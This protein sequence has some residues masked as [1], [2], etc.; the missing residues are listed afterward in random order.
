MFVANSW[1][2]LPDNKRECRAFVY[3][4]PEDVLR[5]IKDERI[6]TIALH[7]TD[8][9]GRWQEVRVPSHVLELQ[10][11]DRGIGV[12]S[13][14]I[15][16]VRQIERDGMLMIPDPATALLDPISEQPTLIM[17]CNIYD[18]IVG[19]RYSGD[20]RSIAQK[21]EAYLLHTDIGETVDFGL[22]LEYFACDEAH[23]EHS[24]RSLDAAKT[25]RG[26]ARCRSNR[27]A[28][29]LPKKTHFSAP[30]PG[31]LE[32][33]S[34]QLVAT[35]EKVGITVEIHNDEVATSGHCKVD[36]APNT[37]TR[38]ADNLMIY[39]YV[40]ENVVRQRGITAN[41][42]PILG[43]R[44]SGVGVYQSIWLG[45]RPLFAGN[46]Y[47]GSAALMR[48]YIAGLVEH[49]AALLPIC[50]RSGK[51]HRPLTPSLRVP[52]NLDYSRFDHSSMPQA[53]MNSRDLKAS[54]AEFRCPGLPGNPYLAFAAML[55]AGIDGFQN[56]LYHLPPDEPLEKLYKPFHELASG[57]FESLLD[58]LETDHAFLLQ[59]DVFTPD[60]I[61]AYLSSR[62]AM[63]SPLDQFPVE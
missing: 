40:V 20:P 25:Q 58:A 29:L 3:K 26:T 31:V 55:M 22:E 51:S 12:S 17:I 36:V 7:F 59:G 45:E 10:S 39:K 11:F 52:V 13:S 46:G 19:Q 14:A 62:E 9:T 37:L 23:I 63:A 5:A 42:I 43:S 44:S 49:A 41:F 54:R 15:R 38:M 18:P 8:L 32:D 27:T 30:P 34:M 24:A 60:V 35:L 53:P 28:T 1:P 48:H 56:R 47:A 61:E 21:A 4:T 50:S 57:S 16:L 2:S 6:L 33:V